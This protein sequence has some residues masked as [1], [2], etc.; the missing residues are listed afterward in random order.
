[1]SVP[2]VVQDPASQRSSCF[3]RMSPTSS[4]SK[5]SLW[6]MLGSQAVNALR[7]IYN[8]QIMRACNLVTL[9]AMVERERL[10]QGQIS[11]LTE[12]L[13]SMIELGIPHASVL[14]IVSPGDVESDYVAIWADWIDVALLHYNVWHGRP[15]HAAWPAQPLQLLACPALPSEY[16][17]HLPFTTS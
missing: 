5:C 8:L 10:Q 1:M 11:L 16:V 2:K 7:N 3:A 17:Q 13:V 4:F 6:D 9:R 14:D 12:R 15:P